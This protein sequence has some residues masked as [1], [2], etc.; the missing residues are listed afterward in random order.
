MTDLTKQA[1]AEFSRA[2]ARLRA[3]EFLCTE[4]GARLQIDGALDQVSAAATAAVRPHES[5]ALRIAGYRL[6]MDVIDAEGP[7]GLV[8]RLESMMGELEATACDSCAG[9]G[10]ILDGHPGDPDAGTPCPMCTT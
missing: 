5:I 7:E 10:Y 9:A 1:I 8:G 3:G 2:R 4:L 6:A